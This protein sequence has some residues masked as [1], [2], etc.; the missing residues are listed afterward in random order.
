MAR[1]GFLPF[2]PTTKIEFKIAER[3]HIKILSKG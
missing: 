2:L 1:S 3:R